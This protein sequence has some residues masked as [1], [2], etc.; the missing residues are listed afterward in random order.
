MAGNTNKGY[1]KGAVKERSQVYNAKTG[2]FVK[3]DKKTGQFIAVKKTPY[4]GVTKEN[5]QK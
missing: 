1:R 4:K 3:R 5:K 2:M